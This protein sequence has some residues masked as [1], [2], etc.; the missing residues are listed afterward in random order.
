VCFSGLGMCVI[1][2]DLGHY[3]ENGKNDVCD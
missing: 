2:L 1:V 3:Q